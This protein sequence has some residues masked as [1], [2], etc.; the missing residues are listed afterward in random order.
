[1]S[2][3]LGFLEEVWTKHLPQHPAP[4]PRH[5]RGLPRRT[6]LRACQVQEKGCK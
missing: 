1:M 4:H 3:F 6:A 5:S 2:A